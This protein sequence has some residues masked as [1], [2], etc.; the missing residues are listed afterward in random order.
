MKNM[1]KL[2]AGIVLC[3]AV[4]CSSFADIVK[5]VYVEKRGGGALDTQSVKAFLSLRPGD[6]LTLQTVSQDLKTL[7]K[8]GR[9]SYVDVTREP[10][11]E[12]TVVTYIV[13]EKPRLRKIIIMG[14]DSLGNKKARD[15]LEINIG[16]YVD[17]AKMAVNSQ[18]LKAEYQTKLFPFATV[19]WVITRDDEL[20]LAD[21][22]V[23][24]NE[25]LRSGIGSISFIGNTV[26]PDKELREVM[27]ETTRKWYSRFTGSGVYNPDILA[28]DTAK[29]Q[30]KYLDA[31]YLDVN[32]GTPIIETDKKDQI[33]IV[34]PIQEGQQ[35]QIGSVTIEGITKYPEETIESQL[36]IAP[37]QIAS[38]AEISKSSDRIRDYYGQRGYISTGVR[39]ERKA[40]IR[41]GVVDI[42]Y[43]VREGDLAYIRDI[44]IRGNVRTQDKVIR[45]ELAVYPGEVMDEVKIRKSRTRLDNLGFFSYVNSSYETT[46]LPHY[47][48][49][50]FEVEEK[51]TGQFLIGAG[52]SSIDNLI[53]FVELGQGNFD[54]LGWPRF[55]GA[56][57]K[58]K[59]RLQLGTER[60]DVTI[61][62]VEPWFLNR[63]LKLGVDIFQN[64]SEYYSDDYDQRNTG[65]SVSLTKPMSSFDR[66]IGSYS[67]QQIRV[68]N[69]DEDASDDIKKEEGSS[70]QS[71]VS[72]AWLHDSR[73]NYFVPT[74]G[75][76]IKPMV[77]LSGG[78]LG[79]DVDMY[80]VEVRASKYIPLWLNHNL[81]MRGWFASVNSYG[82]SDEVRIF[83]RLYLGGGQSLRGYKYREI[84]PVD[85]EE[86]P[87]GG[88][89]A[90]FTSLE[91]SV[92]IMRSVRVA[93]FYDIGMVYSDAFSFDS[94]DYTG[95][96]NDDLGVGVRLDIPGFPLRLDYAWPITAGDY[97][98][99]SNG[100][101]NFMIGY[102]F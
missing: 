49:L 58:M 78:P 101:F 31:G 67:L 75:S 80:K 47:Y 7:Q 19:E 30:Q 40:N 9:F 14:A 43:V 48:D 94:E 35:Y 13:T 51:R 8:S 60:R 82:S 102:L 64:E 27:K 18:K 62:F 73:D 25:G 76:R 24:I 70:L 41:K 11:D 89:T 96:Y 16:E 63:K 99:D 12:G 91:Y 72:V 61:S 85:A 23:T 46:S 10:T 5:D 92:P 71:Q 95:S 68:Y 52:F 39:T 59:V 1:K 86:E 77:S 4:V 26:F 36:T 37:G 90:W 54:I 97:N 29:I 22:E 45:R 53:A 57:Q 81:E 55:T 83:D 56:G 21:V 50:L 42:D 15:M 17:D 88:Q 87:L 84:G 66:L 20:G 34:I 69:V 6:V 28:G 32:V 98:D 3:T 79:A 33:A 44:N 74:T 93:G 100:R 65:A 38:V 2:I